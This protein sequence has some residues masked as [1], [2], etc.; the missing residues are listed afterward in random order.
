MPS[1]SHLNPTFSYNLPRDQSVICQKSTHPQT[2]QPNTSITAHVLHLHNKSPL[3]L[4]LPSLAIYHSPPPTFMS[5]TYPTYILHSTLL[6]T[7][8]PSPSSFLTGPP[9]LPPFTSP[10]HPLYLPSQ[11]FT[12][13]I[14]PLAPSFSLP[15]FYH[16]PPCSSFPSQTTHLLSHNPTTKLSNKYIKFYSHHLT[17]ASH[18]LV[19]T[20]LTYTLPH[21]I[22]QSKKLNPPHSLTQIFHQN[23]PTLHSI[24]QWPPHPPSIPHLIGPPPAPFPHTHNSPPGS[25]RPTVQP[26]QKASTH[27]TSSPPTHGTTNHL[28]TLLHLQHFPVLTFSSTLTTLPPCPHSSQLHYSPLQPHSHTHTL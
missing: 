6:A 9:H 13:A 20:L 15:I 5:P 16:N 19:Y 23:L 27:T 18:N 26:L 11:L 22:P 25:N 24:Y 2:S 28:A 14:T 7:T 4:Y 17:P 10:S 8:Q 3:S 12:P 21:I 1:H